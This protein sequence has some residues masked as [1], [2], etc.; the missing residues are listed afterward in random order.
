M[1]FASEQFGTVS[2]SEEQV[3]RFPQGLPAFE[4]ERDFLPIERPK[5]APVIF[6]QSLMRPGLVFITLPVQV[7][8]A[9]YRLALSPEDL[10]TLDL[11]ADHQPTPG[12]DVLCLVVI[13][14][15]ETAATANLL[16]PIVV[17]LKTK[18]ALQAIQVD[19]DY[20]HQHLLPA[21][22]PQ[23]AECS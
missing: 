5:S 13:T 2:Y 17:N 23:E 6:L 9:A 20:S 12:G 7:V 15:A 8:D 3:I 11:P 4:D 16:A 14:L 22:D 1:E 19:T 21:Q 18:R 10:E